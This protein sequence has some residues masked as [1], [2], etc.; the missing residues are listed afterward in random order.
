LPGKEKYID[1][2]ANLGLPAETAWF[3]IDST[4]PITGFE[5]FGTVDGNQL[6]AYAGGGGT[7]AKSGVFAKIEK[8]GWTGIAFVN[9]EASAASVTLTAYKDNGTTV[10]TQVLPV[11]GHAKVVKP[12]EDIFFSQ[13]ISSA[14]YIAYMLSATTS[15]TDFRAR[16]SWTLGCCQRSL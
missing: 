13:D 1:A 14:T 12:A 5:L 10:A 3:K 4:R 9:T 8:D 11:G 6:A 15:L 7:G 2:V 16:T